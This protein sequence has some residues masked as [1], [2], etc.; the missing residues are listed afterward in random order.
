MDKIRGPSV[1]W[2]GMTDNVD[3]IYELR[4]T[5]HEFRVTSWA[6]RFMGY[7]YIGFIS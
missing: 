3:S 1:K 2:A 7:E 5:G 4:V 6:L